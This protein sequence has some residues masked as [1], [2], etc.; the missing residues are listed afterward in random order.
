M[1]YYSVQQKLLLAVTINLWNKVRL[2]HLAPEHA[3]SF[4]KP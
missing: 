2:T 3:N 4:L 1:K